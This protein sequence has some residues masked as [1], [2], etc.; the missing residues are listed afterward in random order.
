MQKGKT[1]PGWALGE[2]LLDKSF[3]LAFEDPRTAVRFASL[4]VRLS[5]LL[6]RGY[7]P[8]AQLPKKPKT[9]HRGKGKKKKR[10]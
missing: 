3:E 2:Q 1:R 8:F 7:D 4:G 9:G 10:S 5:A 6:A